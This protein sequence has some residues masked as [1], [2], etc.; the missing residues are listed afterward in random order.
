MA[1]PTHETHTTAQLEAER[2]KLRAEH[3]E[4][5]SEHGQ[6][7]QM[8][9]APGTRGAGQTAGS[10]KIDNSSTLSRLYRELSEIDYEIQCAKALEACSL[11]L[12][13]RV[14]VG[15]PRN[16]FGFAA[17]LASE[18]GHDSITGKI[19]IVRR[20]TS[21]G[22]DLLLDFERDRGSDYAPTSR[23]SKLD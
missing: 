15:P 14:L 3:V 16:H 12:G 10:Y 22:F 7:R 17:K 4:A 20:I 19:G 23:C 5:A 1:N 21:D 9:Y 8:I 2:L 11:K 18:F 6:T 13:D